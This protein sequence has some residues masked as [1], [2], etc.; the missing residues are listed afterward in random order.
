MGRKQQD[1]L[2][3][4]G[5]NHG[6]IEKINGQ[7]Y[8]FYHRLTHGSDYS[9]QACAEKITI[10]P[11]GT[12]PQEEVTTQGLNGKPL[13]AEGVYPAAI[14]CNITNG[15]MPNIQFEQ[16]KMNH[17]L[18]R[19]T[20]EGEQHYITGIVNGTMIGYKYFHFNS[21]TRM[22]L[23]LRGK[24]EGTMS[25]SGNDRPF[26]DIHIHTMNEWTESEIM[27]PQVGDSA[28]FLTY[29][30]RGELELLEIR[31]MKQS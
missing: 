6:S 22:V 14:A 16:V 26:G 20:H 13:A 7:W 5:T 23:V 8:V 19:V 2:N 9:R 25:V 3:L 15:H 29:Q 1:A 30:G 24:A 11:D 10:L 18:P 28:L 17:S 12:I 21:E 27:I 4:S 31:Y